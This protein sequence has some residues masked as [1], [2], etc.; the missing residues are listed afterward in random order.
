MLLFVQAPG[1]QP[2][3]ALD[4]GRLDHFS[5]VKT[6]G[7]KQH[8]CRIHKESTIGDHGDLSMTSKSRPAWEGIEY[9]EAVDRKYGGSIANVRVADR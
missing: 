4:S 6:T 3:F 5:S 8:L 9:E 2:G 1:G 7:A